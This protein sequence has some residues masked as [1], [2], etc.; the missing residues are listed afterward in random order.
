MANLK[1]KDPFKLMSTNVSYR[2]SKLLGEGAN[3]VRD[4]FLT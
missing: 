4:L 2:E 1:I 3:E